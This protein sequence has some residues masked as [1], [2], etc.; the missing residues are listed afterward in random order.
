MIES[1]LRV[2]G[3]RPS[4]WPII[5]RFGGR[6]GEQ[7]LAIAAAV[8]LAVP[9]AKW[10][11]RQP[12]RENFT[13]TVAG[14]DDIYPALHEWVLERIPRDARKA[15]IADS[16]EGVDDFVTLRN[17]DD[18]EPVRRVRLRYDGSRTQI[19]R[20]DGHRIEVGVSRE[21]LPGG[22]GQL[23]A[24][25]QRLMERIVFT[26]TSPAG[27]DAVVAVLEQ[28]AAE[29]F[30]VARPPSLLMPARWGGDWSRR[31]D[32]PPRELGSVILKAGQLERLVDDLTAFIGAESEYGRLSQP[33]HRGYLFHG[34]PGTGKT[35]VARALANHFA[36]PVHYLPLGDLERDADLMALVGAIRPRSMLLIE[37][38][39]VYH[40]A[41]DRDDEAPKASLAAML[42]ALDGVW[43]PHGLV[44][45]LTTNDRDALDPALLRPGRVDVMEEF[46]ALDVEQARRLADFCG[47][48][49]PLVDMPA[50]GSWSYWEGKSPAEM[51]EAARRKA[52]Q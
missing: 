5:E 51:I 32:L 6:R 26:A 12:W 24:N 38:V 36:M 48:R 31:D 23:P 2:D 16:R 33:W 18:P 40:A 4:A 14:A 15:L 27:R 52:M 9:S 34:A 19:V 47:F 25:W 50:R 3:Q 42:N 13:I 35:S 46:T 28:L 45:V 43:T 49:T 17:S 30:S 20:I 22:R 29:T 7:L 41:T 39:D 37:D 11:K 10:V 1:T 21:D 8:Q 44:T